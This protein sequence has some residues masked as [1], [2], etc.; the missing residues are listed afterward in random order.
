MTIS[1]TAAKFRVQE[2]TVITWCDKNY[3][4][5]LQRNS[6]GEYVIPSSVK[7]P[8]TGSRSKGDAIYTSIVKGTLNGFDVTASLY[9]LSENEFERYVDQ[10]KTAGVIDSYIDENTRIEYLCRTLKSS[11]F[12]KL[13]RN[14]IKSF[15]KA[16]KP[17]GNINIGVNIG[18]K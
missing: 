15:L 10:L 13:N 12:S 17:N 16:V 14:K 9:G 18:N 2:K 3:I 8:Y 11:E 1:E 7:Q 6:E 4:R 5:G